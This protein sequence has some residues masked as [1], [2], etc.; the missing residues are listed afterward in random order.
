MNP[1]P[2]RVFRIVDNVDP[3]D[4]V[5]PYALLDPDRVQIAIG[6][7]PSELRDFAFRRFGEEIE[8]RHDETPLY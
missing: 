4:R 7:H 1:K 5:H 6:A 2:T 3:K 8:V